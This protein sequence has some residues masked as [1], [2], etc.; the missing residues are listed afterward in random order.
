MQQASKQVSLDWLLN[1]FMAEHPELAAKKLPTQHVVIDSIVKPAPAARHC[2]YV[3]LVGAP[4]SDGRPFYFVS[5]TWSRVFAETVGQLE[6][7]F[8]SEAQ[9]IWRC[10]QPVLPLTDVFVWFDLFAIN[11]HAFEGDLGRLQEVVADA[12]Q[13]QMIIDQEGAVLTRIWCLYEAYQAGLRGPGS[14]AL[15]S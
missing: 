3:D 5:H 1:T 12:E 14:L 9:S 4:V 10:G 2:R 6:E 11:Q 13:T 15:L 8:T 7:H